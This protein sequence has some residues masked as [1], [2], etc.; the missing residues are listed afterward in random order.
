MPASKVAEKGFSDTTG[1]TT[2]QFQTMRY[3]AFR[4]ANF[5]KADVGRAD[6]AKEKLAETWYWKLYE[7][8]LGIIVDKVF[9]RCWPK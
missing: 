7:K 3:R 2:D 9:E 4:L 6:L 5:M 1:Q 8:T